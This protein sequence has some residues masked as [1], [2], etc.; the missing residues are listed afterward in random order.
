M[1][2]GVWPISSVIVIF[3]FQEADPLNTTQQRQG[4]V[5][6]KNILDYLRNEIKTTKKLEL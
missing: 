4:A 1:D 5:L 6:G 2:F 3:C